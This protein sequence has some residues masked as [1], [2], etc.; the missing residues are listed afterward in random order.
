[1]DL[2]LSDEQT[3]LVDLFAS[4]AERFSTSAEVRAHEG[5]GH[6]VELWQQLVAAGAPG[7]ALA[8]DVGG[9]GAGLLDVALAVE[10][11]GERLAPAPLIEHT[12]AARLLARASG[13][14]PDG[15]VDGSTIVTL[16]LRP[17][18]DHVARLVPAG[19]VARRRRRARR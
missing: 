6:S 13:T 3:A 1:M 2:E 5:S 9:A 15:V 11:L 4:I 14:L 18:V 19:A 17:P 12:V 16:A 7:I 8:D 10:V